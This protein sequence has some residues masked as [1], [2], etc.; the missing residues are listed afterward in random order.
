[1]NFKALKPY[2]TQEIANLYDNEEA[3]SLYYMALEKLTGW[4]RSKIIFN[5]EQEIQTTE[6]KLIKDLIVQLQQGK[7]IQYILE[8]AHFYGMTLMVSPAVLIPRAETEELVDWII[9]EV[10]GIQPA[11]NLLDVGTGSGCIAI[12]LKKHLPEWNVAA[13]D[14]SESALKV[15]AHNALQNKVIVEFIHADVLQFQTAQ[16]Y[17]LIVSNPPYIK[18]DEKEQM[19]TNVMEHEPHSALFVSNQNPLVFYK[20][21]AALAEK[22]LN[23]K[24]YLFFEINEYLGQE[25]VEM[26]AAYGFENIVLRKDMQGKDR[27]ICCRKNA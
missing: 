23:E 11:G 12:S 5:Q 4:G 7:P 14:I 2:F 20:A 15:A 27:M 22:N 19:H 3:E 21:I 6:L 26:L 17:D 10:K 13:L 18:E 8:E 1:M 16:K 25:T 24:G 9:E